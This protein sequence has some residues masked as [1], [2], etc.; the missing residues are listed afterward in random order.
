M[1]LRGSSINKDGS[2]PVVRFCLR[3][4]L[5][6]LGYRVV[7]SC[8]SFGE[9]SVMDPYKLGKIT[10]LSAE[11]QMQNEVLAEKRAAMNSGIRRQPAHCSSTAPPQKSIWAWVFILVFLA[12]GYLLYLFNPVVFK[13]I[14]FLIG[15]VSFFW[16]LGVWGILGMVL[17]ALFSC[18]S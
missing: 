4:A 7:N 9:V 1:S 8:L 16:W 10:P 14:L 6:R 17:F 3:L 2:E 5:P 13:L 11:H 12:M 15:L 18:G